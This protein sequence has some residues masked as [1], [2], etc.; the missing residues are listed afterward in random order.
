[1]LIGKFFYPTL[2]FKIKLLTLFLLAILISSCT[3][4]PLATPEKKEFY[5]IPEVTYLRESPGYEERVI[6]QLYQG[7]QV[8]VVENGE[9]PWWRVEQVSDGQTGWVQKALL[10][11]VPVPSSFYYVITDNVPLL[12]LP[13]K[14]S[15]SL[16]LLAKGERVTKLEGNPQGWWQIKTAAT[17]IKGWLLSVALSKKPIINS[18]PPRQ[19]YY[20]AIRNLGLRAK[21]WI[22]DEI[23]KTLHFNEQVQKIA[24]NSQGWFKVRLPADGVQGWVL[25][26][27]L[28]HLPS[29]AP[30]QISPVKTIPKS[31]K[32]KEDPVTE[33]EIM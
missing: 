2:F 8:I 19:Y 25:S 17:G 22:R 1:M 16:A 6:S 9:I 13:K 30:R 20:V 21:P 15:T 10:S 11:D 18:E 33:P 7:D 14:D 12:E 4:V 27:Y 24:Q 28:E 31:P 26:R 3:T 29:I 5:I 23:I 32:Q